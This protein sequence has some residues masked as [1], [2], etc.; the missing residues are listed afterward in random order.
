MKEVKRIGELV[1]ETHNGNLV[2]LGGI[3]VGEIYCTPFEET[4][5]W[6]RATLLEPGERNL[7]ATAAGVFLDDHPAGYKK[8]SVARYYIDDLVAANGKA[9]YEAQKYARKIDE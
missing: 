9:K 5:G 4:R 3:R 1:S 6:M 2:M 7:P 8:G